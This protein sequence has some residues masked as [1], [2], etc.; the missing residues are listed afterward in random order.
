MIAGLA[1]FAAAGIILFVAPRWAFLPLAVFVLLCLMAPFFHSAGF[2]LRVISRGQTGRAAVALTFDDG[3]DPET[4]GPLL[5]LLKRYDVYASF[6]VTG[7]KAA[8]HD[9]LIS[10]ILQDGHE[11]GNHT[12]NHNVFLM[13]NRSA[14]IRREI[15]S[16]QDVL[17]PFGIYPVA[18][19]PPVGI[20]S[21][22]LPEILSS[23]GM[24]ALTFS[25]R[26]E[27]F[28]NRRVRR[29]S[30]RILNKVRPDDIILLHDLRPTC[31]EAAV[32]LREIDLILS[33]LKEKGLQVIPLREL[34]GKPVMNRIA[35]PVHR[36]NIDI[37]MD[38]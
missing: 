33:G 6:F 29:L 28:G 13:L 3:P 37:P 34:T 5:E 25:C 36:L 38:R 26:A 31:S 27:D 23:L 12:F 10:R 24:Y 21:P 19:R 7:K 32:W 1:A 35:G 2:F 22:K 30:S 16:T 18:F 15:K 14:T 11:I 8:E 9:D 4:T 20:I 17:M